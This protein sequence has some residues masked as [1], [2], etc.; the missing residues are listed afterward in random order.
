M[1]EL[2]IVIAII[3]VLSGVA[4]INIISYQRSL[5]RMELDGIAKEI[6]VAAQNHLTM[7]NSQG[8]L[9]DES[10]RGVNTS[11]NSGVY[12]LKHTAG[13]GS[14]SD[15]LNLLLP[16]GS[17]D[18]TIRSG[19]NYV[20]SYQYSTAK[21]LNVFYAEEKGKQELEAAEYGTLVDDYGSDEN[22]QK[23]KRE[24]KEVGW[25][26]GTSED[27]I[28]EGKTLKTPKIKVTNAEKLSVEIENP[29]G[30]GEGGY[31]LRLIVKGESSG[32][33]QYIDLMIDN[34]NAKKFSDKEDTYVSGSETNKYT[35]ILDDVT[36]A[37]AI[38]HFSGRFTK[39]T[40]GE[41]I[42]IEA[43]AYNNAKLTN[44]AYSTKVKTNSLY[45][46]VGEKVE[47][48]GLSQTT[49]KVA[50]I[51]NFRHLEN[52]ST[53]ISG[54]NLGSAGVKPLEVDKAEQIS[55][56]DWVKF[57]MKIGLEHIY[58][59]G[60]NGGTALTAQDN[61]KPVD[62]SGIAYE[63]KERTTPTEGESKYPKISN[64][65]INESSNAGLFGSLTDVSVS[66]L[67]LV[68][69]SVTSSSGNAGALAGTT[70]KTGSGTGTTVTNVLAHNSTDAVDATI[71]AAGNAGGLIGSMNGGSVQKSA[72]ALVVSS[73]GGDAGGLI[74]AVTG[75]TVTGCYS[76]GHTVNG[77]Y[78]DTDYNVSST[79]GS[80]GGLIGTFGGTKIEYSYSTC[81]ANG[82]TAGGLVGTASSGEIGYCYSAGRVSGDTKQG[83][84]IG[85]NAATLTKTGTGESQ[86]P[87]NYYY[88][89]INEEKGDDGKISY[90]SPIG[91]DT[92]ST[93][94]AKL[95]ESAASYEEFV[96]AGWKDAKSYD[97]SL[98]TY[99]NKEY[100][101]KT[102]KKLGAA[103]E[104]SD[105]VATH[106]GDWPA[107]EIFVINTGTSGGSGS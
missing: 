43:V 2:L 82:G 59:Y 27:T 29:S 21:I 58:I 42:T 38:D 23:K 34:S 99:Y 56:L 22:D 33:E 54:V 49:E 68:D 36:S 32:N 70:L 80:A 90:V 10:K 28:P 71:T 44:I 1:A 88:E 31:G 6:F 93:D 87:T 65:S 13:S 63:G 12:V 26:G 107:P 55:D 4:F 81:S 105:F 51:A 5:R 41:N 64:V 57:K 91:S 52:L 46:S 77:M 47:G 100:P 15:A 53:A 19:G 14:F 62:L 98:A 73:T 30:N 101:L 97:E 37:D 8:L 76:G 18:E 104:D 48:E 75:G 95:D 3:A 16:F 66:N 106:Y 94:V 35:V 40:P 84:F 89:I 74:G 17:I 102:V 9:D 11:D 86:E 67:E 72:A 24:D 79:S 39:F 61:Y 78:S 85:S 83:S 69:F 7:A 103:I 92:G 50:E 96:G 60:S 20:I 25:Y 45:A